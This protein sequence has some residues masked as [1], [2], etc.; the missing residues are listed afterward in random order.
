MLKNSVQVEIWL[1]KRRRETK[2]IS[3]SVRSSTRSFQRATLP[4]G[5]I[6][7]ERVVL[8]LSPG[9]EEQNSDVTGRDLPKRS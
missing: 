7:D 6:G 1:K 3:P 4:V 8:S 2:E 9:E 5:P